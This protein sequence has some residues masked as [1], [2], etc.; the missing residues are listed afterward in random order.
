MNSSKNWHLLL[1]P[2]LKRSSFPKKI[3]NICFWSCPFGLGFFFSIP[4]YGLLI[5]IF[6]FQ[7][8]KD[9][10][11]AQSTRVIL[12]LTAVQMSVHLTTH[13]RSR[14]CLPNPS[15][16]FLLLPGPQRV[17]TKPQQTASTGKKKSR[18]S[19][20]SPASPSSL[21]HHRE[22]TPAPRRRINM[23]QLEVE[24]CIS[25]PHLL[26]PFLL[27]FMEVFWQGEGRAGDSGSVTC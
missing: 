20:T 24:C 13:S 14:W 17:K 2:Q 10:F 4:F 19:P 5:S 3:P 12:P 11:W 23:G 1:L 8:S 7:S 16:P 26:S 9:I 18:V 22:N 25:S 21:Q 27:F 15:Q 6:H